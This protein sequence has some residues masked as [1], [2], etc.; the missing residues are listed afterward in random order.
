VN[1]VLIVGLSL[2]GLTAC[3][4]EEGPST[5]TH[6]RWAA[7]CEEMERN[8]D[9]FWEVSVGACR[10]ADSLSEAQIA[11]LLKFY[12]AAQSAEDKVRN[13]EAEGRQKGY[14]Q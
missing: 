3:G 4:G 7:A 5:S 9:K 11:E 12:E 6:E 13:V 14:T 1:K 2:F 10:N 8:N